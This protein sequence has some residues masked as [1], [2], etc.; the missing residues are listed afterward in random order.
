M[1]T[2]PEYSRAVRSPP[3]RG[4]GRSIRRC[5]SA[6][7]TR[8]MHCR[9]ASC[10]SR[11][12]AATP[13]AVGTV[14]LVHRRHAVHEPR[15]DADGQHRPRRP[16]R[17][18]STTTP[19][20]CATSRPAR[21]CS[22]TTP[23][24]R[25][26]GCRRTTG[27]TGSTC[28]HCPEHYAF[29][30]SLETVADR[31]LSRAQPAPRQPAHRRDQVVEDDRLR[32][33]AGEA[34]GL[35]GVAHLAA[36]VRGHRDDR[37]AGAAGLAADL[38]GRGEAVEPRHLQVHQDQP[39]AVALGHLDPLDAVGRDH[40]LVAAL[41]QHR[42]QDHRVD[43]VVLD[44]EDRAG[45]R[46]AA[47]GAPQAASRASPSAVDDVEARREGRRSSRGRARSSTS[48][49]PPIIRARF[50]LM[51]RPRP[52]PSV[53]AGQRA[54]DLVEA[55]EDVRQRLGAGCRG[56]C[57]RPRRRGRRGRP[58][59]RAARR[60]VDAAAV[61]ELDRVAEQVG[62]DLPE[63]PAVAAHG[64]AVERRPVALEA[65]RLLVGGDPHHLGRRPSGSRPARTAR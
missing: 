1:F 6:T 61:G 2:G 26:A 16:G 32:Q 7:A 37:R 50:W 44:D 55:L 28:D 38:G 41:A 56:R 15:R 17:R 54:V 11:C 53:A 25:T 27:S 18:C 39:R 4:S 59:A 22:R 20:R 21:S 14:P 23:S 52:V 12:T 30:C 46:P 33:H 29:L 24:G 13:Q 63:R 48:M 8:C 57:R 34:G 9:R 35:A 62:D 60:S 36:G 10:A 65:D 40:R 58:R 5:T 43:L 51:A 19:S 31:G 64:Q 3:G 45:G 49:R 47:L 42:P